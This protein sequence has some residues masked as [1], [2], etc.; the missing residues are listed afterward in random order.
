MRGDFPR[1]LTKV[2]H[3]PRRFDR[4][5][6][7]IFLNAS[8]QSFCLLCE[9]FRKEDR[10]LREGRA[11]RRRIG[12]CALGTA[13]YINVRLMDLRLSTEVDAVSVI[14]TVKRTGGAVGCP[15][16]SPRGRQRPKPPSV[17]RIC[18]VIHDASSVTSH[19]MSR[20]GSSGCPNRP[21]GNMGF[22]ECHVASS[23]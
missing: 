19:A 1:V 10:N 16:H 9:L 2:T 18:P 12:A 5:E 8:L 23:M 6:L 20:A 7:K 14:L 21:K 22:T 13:T 17:L 15:D 3:H 4:V 11:F